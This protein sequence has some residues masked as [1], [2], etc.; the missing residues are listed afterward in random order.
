MYLLTSHHPVYVT[1]GR[2]W[3]ERGWHADILLA[4]DWL[5]APFGQLTVLCPSLPFDASHEIS[6]RLLPIGEHDHVRVV[7]SFDLQAQG[8]RFWFAQRSQW[9]ADVRRELRTAK[10]IQCS[11]VANIFR[12]LWYLAHMAGV[13]A[14]MTT[15]LLGPDVDPRLSPRNLQE[16]LLWKAF[17]WQFKRAAR[18]ADLV[19]LRE[20]AVFRRYA[21][22]ARVKEEFCDSRHHAQDAIG[23]EQLARRLATLTQDR[24]LRAVYAGPLLR[25]Y[26]LF[27]AVEALAQARRRG[28]PIEYHLYGIGPDEAALRRHAAARGVVAQVH[29]HGGAV[30]GPGFIAQL[31]AYDMLLFLP[32]GEDAPRMLYDALAA[33]LPLVG[34]RVPFLEHQV[35]TGRVG[36]LVARGN[37][38]AAA[39]AL[40]WLHTYR[41]QLRAVSQCAAAAGRRNSIEHWYS[42]R[43][44]WT[45]EAVARHGRLSS[46]EEMAWSA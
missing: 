13:Q 43:A 39:D 31:A 32:L 37:A 35:N 34:S 18:R 11:A 1:D 30:T 41:N 10:V 2:A 42:R 19:L 9:L 21:T 28:A 36:V 44:Q 17:D 3:V 15:V 14:D 6:R 12:P 20:G 24:P 8:R 16:R 33:G 46:C 7:P 23:E 29:F 45:Q 25:R 26:G 22:C 27:E 40:C 4:R 38:A 5:A